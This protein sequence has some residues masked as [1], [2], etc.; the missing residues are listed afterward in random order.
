[1][2]ADIKKQHMIDH[3]NYS[4]QPRKPAERKRRMTQKK[5]AALSKISVTM[6]NQNSQASS[7]GVPGTAASSTP[8]FTL[9]TM[10]NDKPKDFFNPPQEIQFNEAGNAIFP[11]GGTDTSDEDLRM[12]LD[13]YNKE[14]PPPHPP[15]A[16]PLIPWIDPETLSPFTAIE[17]SNEATE[18]VNYYDAE[19]NWDLVTRE[20]N[21]LLYIKEITSLIEQVQI[22]CKNHSPKYDITT[23]NRLS[24]NFLDAELQRFDWD[25]GDLRDFLI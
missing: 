13:D 20:S 25:A 8:K 15:P 2:A 12:M 24:P 19:F 3:P 21:S 22:N 23:W 9:F 17:R 7:S 14:I 6:P 10:L 4:Y 16:N 1:M 11:L 5:A 18:N